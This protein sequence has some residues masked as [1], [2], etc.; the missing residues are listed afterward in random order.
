MENWLTFAPKICKITVFY[1]DTSADKHGKLIN[2]CSKN[3]QNNGITYKTTQR[4]EM[5]RNLL[6]PQTF[7]C[8]ELNKAS[9]E[10]WQYFRKA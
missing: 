1:A 7:K 5:S 3:L 6:V 9:F 10:I 2:I 8:F 4:S